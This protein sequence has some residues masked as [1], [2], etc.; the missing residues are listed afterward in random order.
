MEENLNVIEKELAT[1]KKRKNECMEKIA[2]AD[3][4]QAKLNDDFVKK[5]N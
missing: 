3:A 5:K 2:E 4:K 1:S